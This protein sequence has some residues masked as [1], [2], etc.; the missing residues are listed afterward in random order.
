[1]ANEKAAQAGDNSVPAVSDPMAQLLAGVDKLQ[2]PHEIIA[3]FEA[4]GL[5]FS[6]GEEVTGGFRIVRE[7]AREEFMQQHVGQTV[8]VTD[9]TFLDGDFGG[10]ADIRIVTRQGKFRISDGSQGIFEQL[11]TVTQKRNED[12]EDGMLPQAG[13]LVKNGFRQ[14]GNYYYDERTKKAI[15]NNQLETVP[16][17]F[18]KPGKPI[19]YFAF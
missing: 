9:W 3:Y 7:T 12:P 14:S 10:Y 2:E 6:E 17:E 1:M 4:Q 15:P 19:W 16:A 8:F 11:K 13:L 5:K 18:R